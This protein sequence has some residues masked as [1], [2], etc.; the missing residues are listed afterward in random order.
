MRFAVGDTV[1]FFWRDRRYA[2][3]KILAFDEHHEFAKVQLDRDTIRYYPLNQLRP[4][5]NT[6]ISLRYVIYYIIEKLGMNP[7]P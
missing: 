4:T 6:R 3:G 7:Y 1:S 2:K 5:I